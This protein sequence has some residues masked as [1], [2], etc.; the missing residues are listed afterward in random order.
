MKREMSR[1]A[2]HISL[3]TSHLCNGLIKSKK[4]SSINAGEPAGFNERL[5]GLLNLAQILSEQLNLNEIL[6]LIAQKAIALFDAETALIMLLN[7]RTQNTVK[8][9]FRDGRE[10]GEER[11]RLVQINVCGWVLNNKRPFV[12]KDLYFLILIKG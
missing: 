12:S 8:T 6:R 7:P 9:I 5:D 1:F 3:H 11:F 10:L 4:D 2:H